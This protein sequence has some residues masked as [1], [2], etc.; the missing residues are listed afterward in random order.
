MVDC[1]SPLDT[2][3]SLEVKEISSLF[4]N[5]QFYKIR[6]GAEIDW[7]IA[8]S[9]SGA[10]RALSQEEIDL[11]L[12][13]SFTEEEYNYLI[14]NIEKTTG[15]DVKSIEI[16][17]R[18]K[19]DKI[20]QIRDLQELVH[21]CLT[22]EDIDNTAYCILLWRAIQEVICPAL[23]KVYAAINKI[24]LSFR[25]QP[26]LALTHGQPAIPTT[27]GK[28]FRVFQERLMPQL[29]LL[30]EH[31]FFLKTSGAV[32]NS[33]AL[34]VTFP[35]ASGLNI[36]RAFKDQTLT[37]IKPAGFHFFHTE[38]TGQVANQDNFPML[39]D[40]LRRINNI[41]ISL[42]QDIWLYLSRGVLFTESK[43]V[44]SSTMP[45]KINPISFENAEGNLQLANSLFELFSDKLP[46]TRLQRDMSDKTVKRNFGVSLGHSLLAYKMLIKG[47]TSLQCNESV[48]LAE[49]NNHPEVIME[50]I[51]SILRVS[52]IKDA[53]N[54]IR[55]FSQGKKIT[56]EELRSYLDTLNLPEEV[57]LR[58]KA[59][60]PINYI[61]CAETI[62]T[63][64]A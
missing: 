28:E 35:G 20:P 42:S 31:Q 29:E 55:E 38:T 4:S 1:L 54:L 58:L 64:G 62:A 25:K 45:Q 17:L 59:I 3:Y 33:N 6:L 44:G 24:A 36:G 10:I 13:I 39:F 11:L 23:V 43:Q 8:L 12:S 53:Y 49:L 61:G 30:R 46:I 7:L 51:Q 37:R 52:G 40:A 2:R 32:G 48:C 41:L 50:G 16:Y 19:I 56:L 21:I 60:T 14:N 63:G 57:L 5:Y 18:E 9:R 26:L 22:S 27:L 15:H 34:R 47:L